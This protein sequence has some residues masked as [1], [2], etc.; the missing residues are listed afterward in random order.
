MTIETKY[1]IG[2]EVY[3]IG[4]N[5][6]N[7]GTIIGIRPVRGETSIITYYQNENKYSLKCNEYNDFDAFELDLM[8]EESLFT[9]KEELLK[10]L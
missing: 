4:K 6:I 7:K 8:P 5:K 9:S 2:D 1:N 3:F 10:S